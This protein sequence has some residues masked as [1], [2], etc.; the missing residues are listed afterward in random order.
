[1][2]K[3][4]LDK[5]EDNAD[6]RIW[7]EK[8]QQ[9]KCDSL[10]EGYVSKLWD[11]TRISKSLWDLILAHLDTKKRVDIFDLSIY[12]LVI[13]P[14]APDHIDDAVSD[15]LDR[16]DKRVM[17]VQE[18]LAENFRFLSACWRAGEG[19]FIGYAQLLLAWFH[20]HFWKDISEEK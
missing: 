12:G 20:N 5:V 16:L 18:I 11:F 7:S 1:M 19:R 9:E 3:G 14:K 2:E 6:V 10:T 13:F 8:T 17:Y 15:L 4:F